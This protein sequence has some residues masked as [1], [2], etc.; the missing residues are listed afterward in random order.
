VLERGELGFDGGVE[1]GLAFY[2][3]LLAHRPG[4]GDGSLH[5]VV[6]PAVQ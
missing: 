1:E 5:T 6:Q 4:H 3:R 2:E